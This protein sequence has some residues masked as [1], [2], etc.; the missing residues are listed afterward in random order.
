MSGP[1]TPTPLATPVYASSAAA[2]GATPVP[3]VSP[4]AY[5]LAPT[6]VDLNHLVPGGDAVAQAQS[7]YDTLARASAWM[8]SYCFGADLSE[9]GASF[10]ASLSVE[11]AYARV[12]NGEVP[13]VCDYKP[14]LMLVGCD[15]GA[16]PQGVSSI[17]ALAGN[18]RIGQR[19]IYVPYLV[20]SPSRP[21]N[22]QSIAYPSPAAVG[23]VYAVWSYVAGYVHTQLAASAAAGATTI[24]VAS[25]DGAGGVWGV[26]PGQTRLRISDGAL[27][28]RVGVTAITPGT[29]TAL[30]T[31]TPLVNPH[32]LPVAPDFTPVTALPRSL[33]Q[34]AIFVT[35]VLIKTRGS[36]A[37][38]LPQSPGGQP[39]AQS[40]AQAGA[41]EDWTAAERIL[42]PYVVHLRAKV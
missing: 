25:T 3:Y 4:A 10:A 20:G 12:R 41:L 17:G 30:L 42:R 31:T 27:T 19:T 33:E 2:I 35:S 22:A 29:T 39:R 8:D 14:V 32:T 40:F 24:E 6:A 38:V 36:R 16:T 21:N 23:R 28:E 13:L 5:N 1:Y 18:V 34:A 9:T 11:S 7:L 37:L 26:V 15:I